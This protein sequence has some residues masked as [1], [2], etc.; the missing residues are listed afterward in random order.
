MPWSN[1]S[2]GIATSTL[3]AAGSCGSGQYNILAYLTST[4]A[5]AVAGAAAVGVTLNWTDAAGTK[6]AQTLP[7]R[8]NSNLS[9]SGTL[10]LGTTTD[11]ASG[12][13]SIWSTGTNDIQYGTT[14]T[15]CSSGTG[16]YALR[17]VAVQVQ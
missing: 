8:V 14:Y 4:A 11:Y 17:L 10:N 12:Q 15:G 13:M 9:L 5:C 2:G 7:L 1:Q 6:S 16:T 3:C